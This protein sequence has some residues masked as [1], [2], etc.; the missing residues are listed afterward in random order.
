MVEALFG[1]DPFPYGIAANLATIEAMTQYSFEQGLAAR[2]L[3][4][5]ELFAPETWDT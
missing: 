5:K 2:K 4:P 3:D 1:G